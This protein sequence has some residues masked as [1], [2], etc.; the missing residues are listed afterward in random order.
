MA[1]K[2]KA[3]G[4]K[5]RSDAAKRGWETRRQKKI[6][7]LLQYEK[8]ASQLSKPPPKKTRTKT[9]R[10]LEENTRLR[11]DLR[12]AREARM[13]VEKR[14]KEA[15]LKQDELISH[16]EKEKGDIERKIRA[17]KQREKYLDE[18]VPVTDQK[19]LRQDG[20]LALNASTLRHREESDQLW[21]KLDALVDDPNEFREYAEELADFYDADIGEVYDFYFSP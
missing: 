8:V 2:R 18:F 4:W 11:E 5:K 12:I 14:E 20:T 15:R 6:Q 21:L 10:L 9:Q 19:W 13:A 16:L 3:K 7:T 1:A 17:E